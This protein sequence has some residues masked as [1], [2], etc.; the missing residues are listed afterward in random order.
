MLILLVKDA[1]KRPGINILFYEVLS[2]GQN[3]I[4]APHQAPQT[5]GHERTYL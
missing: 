5:T 4:D 2:C 1:K 3:V